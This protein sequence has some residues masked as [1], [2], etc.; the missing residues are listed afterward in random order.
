[1]HLTQLVSNCYNSRVNITK[2]NEFEVGKRLDVVLAASFE[3][4]SRSSLEKLIINGD[5]KVNGEVKRSNYK[6]KA[7]D[8]IEVDLGIFNQPVKDIEIPILYEDDNVVVL[9]KPEGI[10]THAKGTLHNEATVATWLKAH[11]TGVIPSAVE[12]SSENTS[13]LSTIA[14]D[15]GKTS[16]WSSNRAGIVHRLDRGTSGIIICAKNEATQV[17]LQKQFA[18]RN[19]KKTYL[20]VISNELPETE[21]LI[22]LPIERNPKKPAT[23]RVG[24]NGKSAQTEFE[25]LEKRGKYSLIELKPHTGRTHQL[26]V[27]LNYLKCP[28]VGDV[29]YGG[30]EFSRL[31]LHAHQLEV[32]LPGGKRKVFTAEI[33]RI[34]KELS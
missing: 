30:E 29:V 5:V 28:I 15:D 19:V 2:I 9:N 12:G 3:Q 33:P 16:F 13:D 31:M 11:V 4:Y 23:F 25:L 22:D 24:I 10:L 17:H 34:F 32:T 26:R 6:L 21:G 1:M 8:Q 27:H 7:G 18:G 20:A 14:Q